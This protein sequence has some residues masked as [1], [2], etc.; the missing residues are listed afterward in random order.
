[1]VVSI[2]LV[3][4]ALSSITLRKAPGPDHLYPEHFYHGPIDYL[5][6]LLAPL[7]QAMIS[8]HYVPPVF[9]SSFILPIP[10]SRSMDMSDPSNY[11]GI[12]IGSVF[13]NVIEFVLH[14][15]FLD[16]LEGKIHHGLQGGFRKGYGTSHTSF[17]LQ[18]AILA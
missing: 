2:D 4:I 15:G 17:I 14:K 6:Q 8:F 13:S 5:A 10:K 11:R 16:N 1:M 18:E 7:F 12:F 3:R 9:I